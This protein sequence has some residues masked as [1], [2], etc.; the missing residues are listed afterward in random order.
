MVILSMKK[1]EGSGQ[2]HTISKVFFVL[3]TYFGQFLIAKFP[4]VFHTSKG[5]SE[6]TVKQDGPSLESSSHLNVN[7]RYVGP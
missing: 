7:L 5:V 6:K 3:Q 2:I 4:D 1:G